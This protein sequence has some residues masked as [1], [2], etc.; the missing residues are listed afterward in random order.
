MKNLYSIHFYYKR[1]NN[2]WLHLSHSC[3]F[4]KTEVNTRVY[5]FIYVDY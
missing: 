1:T 2:G 3:Y 4:Y 5:L